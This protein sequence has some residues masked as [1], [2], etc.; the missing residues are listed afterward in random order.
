M[1]D[2]L[3]TS[4]FCPGTFNLIVA[5]CGCGKTTAAINKIAALASAPRKALFLI[6]T[7]NGN[8]R[9][10]MNDA[11][12]KPYTFFE[13]YAGTAALPFGEEDLPDK[14]VV[15]TYAQFGVWVSREPAFAARFDIIICDEAHNIVVFP[16]FS[17]Q[18][19]FASIARDAICEAAQRGKTLVVG[20]TATP[21]PLERL[22]CPI[23]RIPIDASN[24]R[25]YENRNTVAYSSLRQTIEGL[26]SDAKGALYVPHIRMMKKCEELAIAAGRKPICVWSLANA[27]HPMNEEQLAARRY[28]LENEALPPQY[29]LFI[30]NGSCE[31]SINIRS[32]MDFFIVHNANPTHI[33][34]ARGRYRGDLE[35]LYCFD[36]DAEEPLIV[37]QEFLEI[38]LYKEEQEHL[39]L[40]LGLAKD[41]SGHPYPK[42]KMY[43][44]LEVSGYRIEHK[45]YNNRHYVMIF[46]KSPL[47]DADE[48]LGFGK[49]EAYNQQEF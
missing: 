43:E 27:E 30:L 21:E 23:N 11:L 15:T 12:T 10:A 2:V 20:M 4:A 22:N 45:R 35:T 14:I 17:P 28:I 16:T 40:S 29:D 46:D 39:R 26:P 7:R 47:D 19:N 42:G 1:E 34:Q 32:H 33:T 36:R 25:Q 18:P 38:R 44:R 24:L 6:D 9:L 49:K 37:P 8:E 3:D 41:R 31:T 13:M 48:V 5:P